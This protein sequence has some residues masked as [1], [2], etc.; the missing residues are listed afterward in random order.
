MTTRPVYVLSAAAPAAATRLLPLLVSLVV[1]VLSASAQESIR[2]SSTGAEASAARKG[3]EFSSNYNIK[4]GPVTFDASGSLDI[5]FDDNV[6]L[7]EKDRHSDIIFRPTIRV[8]SLWRVSQLNTLRLAFG[9]GFEKYLDHSDLDSR[10]VLLDPGSEVSFDIYIGGNLRLNIHDRFA[11]EQNPT[12]EANL[13]NSARF[14]RFL[15]SAGV[16]AFW[17]FNDLKIVLGYDHFDYR[18]LNSNFDYL[19][20]REEQFLGSASL[21]LS[22]A[23]TAGLDANVAVVSF[24]QNFNNDGTTWSAGPFWRWCFLPIRS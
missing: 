18:S 5:E 6:G 16:T 1:G 7:A 14:D 17:D 4:A 2:P 8:D 11:I 20:R 3:S 21:N 22:D 9:I 13:S 12:D 23:I 24:D 19:S 10:N 15:N